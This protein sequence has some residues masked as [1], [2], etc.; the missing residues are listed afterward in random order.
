MDKLNK[1][2]FFRLTKVDEA[3]RTV[4]G[5]ATAEQPDKTGEV[6]DYES[7]KPYYEKWSEGFRKATDGKS[8]GNVRAMHTSVAAGK[9]TALDFDDV[10]K[11]IKITAK[12]VDDSEWKKVEEGVYTGFSQGGAYI[13]KWKDGD[14]TRYTADPTEVSIV[15]NPCLGSATFQVVKENGATEMRKFHVKPDDE[16][17]DEAE[18]TTEPAVEQ[19]WRATDGS[20]H[21]TKAE[22]QKRNHMVEA[23]KTAKAA[24]AGLT[25]LM[26][27][28]NDK[29]DEDLYWKRDITEEDRAALVKSGEALEDGSYPVRNEDDLKNA[30]RSIGRAKDVSKAKSHIKKRA[31]DLKLE[32]LIPEDWKVKKRVFKGLYDVA[33]AASLIESLDW[34]HTSISWEA[35]S[36]GD[37]SPQ[38]NRLADIIKELCGFLDALVEEECGELM[39]GKGSDADLE[40]AAGLRPSHAEAIRKRIKLDGLDEKHPARKLAAALAQ[41]MEKRDEDEAH[42]SRVEAVHKCAGKVMEHCMKAMHSMNADDEDTAEKLLK[43][44]SEASDHMKKAHKGGQEIMQHCMKMGSK[45]DPDEDDEENHKMMKMQT[46]NDV[47]TKTIGD[48]TTQLGGLLKRID[49]LERQPAVR[50]GVVFDVSKSHE[51]AAGEPVETASYSPDALRLSPEAERR[52]NSVK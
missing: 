28:I 46:V 26:D 12:I 7:T 36:E 51:A 8:L 13:R 6:C 24:T 21:K 41:A 25:K 11:E 44:L 10:Q 22:A 17:A 31:K 32:G 43:S 23:E 20:F 15:D 5:I 14:F 2:I 47:L 30:I 34:L 16:P 18:K 40:A 9:V 52:I 35:E 39:A 38:P 50:K 3:Q 42:E 1:P 33:R 19:G 27:D 29:L 4:E 37:G 49:H 48:M 45:V